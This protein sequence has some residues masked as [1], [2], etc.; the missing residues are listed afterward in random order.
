MRPIL[1]V[2]I[3]AMFTL[4]GVIYFKGSQNGMPDTYADVCSTTSD[5]ITGAENCAG[6]KDGKY[7]EMGKGSIDNFLQLDMGQDQEGTGNLTLFYATGN[8]VDIAVEFVK[9]EDEM[10]RVL[11][12]ET[13][14]LSKEHTENF[15]TYG[16]TPQPYRYVRIYI[17]SER[18]YQL[19]A[20]QAET[21]RPDS[22][23][24]GLDDDYELTYGLNPLV[25][26]GDN[27]PKGDLDSDWLTNKEEYDNGKLNPRN[28][29]TDGDGIPDYW[30][31]KNKLDA[32]SDAGKGGYEVD[33]D[34]DGLSDGLE[35]E[36]KSNPHK[37]DTDED[38]LTDGEEVHKYGTDP[39]KGDTDGDKMGDKWES[40]YLP[41]FNPTIPNNP[42]G[43]EDNDGLSNIR[44]SEA[45]T[46]PMNTDSDG[47]CENDLDEVNQ[48][49]NPNKWEDGDCDD[50]GLK[51][52]DENEKYKTDPTKS[53]TDGD[54]LPD[55]WEIEHDFDPLISTGND[56]ASGD[57][58][59]DDVT[60]M[61]EFASETDPHSEDTD[62]DGLPDVWEIRHCI[63]PKDK[64]GANGPNGDPDGNGYTNFMDMGRG[65]LP[66]LNC[67]PTP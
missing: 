49:T 20:I 32:N 14:H 40:K 21:A 29:D 61:L 30:E 63:S 56:G 53:D 64:N 51:N 4:I 6:G 50:D 36:H 12:R 35:Y 62:G 22:D 7:V 18:K 31:V 60:N 1:S 58:D 27:G 11:E 19:D 28:S 17:S 42:D 23:H 2:A 3:L 13:V 5:K 57:P 67:T 59:H 41:T 48:G 44:E 9:L 66:P 52:G 10:E 39:I 15:V 33:T 54:G 37:A 65:T 16:N 24:D 46:A 38:G 47:D 43:D 26:T 25:G 34:E 8:D 55:N 45:N